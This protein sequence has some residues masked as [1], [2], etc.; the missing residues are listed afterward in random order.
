MTSTGAVA[1]GGIT[2]AIGEKN[3]AQQEQDADHHRGEAGASALAI[4]PPRSR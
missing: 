3:S 1:S 2:P 4:R